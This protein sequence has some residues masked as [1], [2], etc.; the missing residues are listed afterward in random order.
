MALLADTV[1]P[2]D[3]HPEEGKS[4]VPADVSIM[5]EARVAL[6]VDPWRV[7]VA[8]GDEVPMPTLLLTVST[9]RTVVPNDF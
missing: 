5:G 7:R 4:S 3:V 9:P 2:V 6:L 1:H 8:V